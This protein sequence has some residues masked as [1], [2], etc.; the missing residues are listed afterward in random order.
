MGNLNIRKMNSKFHLVSLKVLG[1][2][3]LRVS[4]ISK[5]FKK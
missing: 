2:S 5:F 4:L 1:I 3:S